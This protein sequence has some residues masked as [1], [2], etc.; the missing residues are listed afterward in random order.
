MIHTE[1]QAGPSESQSW[2]WFGSHYGTLSFARHQESVKPLIMEAS[3]ANVNVAI[4]QGQ[5][6]AFIASKETGKEVYGDHVMSR[7]RDSQRYDWGKNMPWSFRSVVLHKIGR[8]SL[9]W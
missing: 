1:G 9:P 4:A 2:L 6:T 7:D 5:M 8:D 3:V